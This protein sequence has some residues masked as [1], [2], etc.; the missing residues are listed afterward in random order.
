MR[1]GLAV[2]LCHAQGRLHTSGDVV[3]VVGDLGEDRRRADI[4]ALR[5]ERGDPKNG[6]R[7]GCHEWAAGVTVATAR[8]DPA[9][10]LDHPAGSDHEPLLERPAEGALGGLDLPVHVG[11]HE[12][13]GQSAVLVETPAVDA[14]L[15][16]HLA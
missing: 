8:V 15:G 12:V 16:R 5:A 7:V 14:H 1:W 13:A 11:V 2:D 6:G 4:A 9:L 3:S 10:A